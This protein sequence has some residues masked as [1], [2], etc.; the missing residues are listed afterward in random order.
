LKWFVE[1]LA[2]DDLIK[3]IDELPKVCS[4]KLFVKYNLGG[5]VTNHF[6]ASPFHAINFL[7]PDKFKEWEFNT[8]KHF[9]TDD[10]NKTRILHW[11]IEKL[12][13]EKIITSIEDIP[14]R[15]DINTFENY[16]LGSFVRHNFDG[17]SYKAFNFLF[18]DKWHPWEF[19]SCPIGYWKDKNNVK[20]ALEWFVDRLIERGTIDSVDQLRNLPVTKLFSEFNLLSISKEYN[21][22]YGLLFS[23]IL[24]NYFSLEDFG[25][26]FYAFDGTKLD[27]KEEVLIHEWLIS[28][29]KKVMYF[30]NNGKQEFKWHNEKMNENYVA[31]WMINDNIIIEYFGWYNPT[32]KHQR[33][34]S[35]NNKVNRKIDYFNGLDNFK[36]VPLF[37]KDI[38]KNLE[39]VR[40]KIKEVI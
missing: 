14:E 20:H 33:Y 16:N 24:P 35:Y 39:G 37:P 1:K 9:M 34:V 25:K 28:N 11:F 23:T 36:F 8:P 2:Q 32:S 30:N 13:E 15:V 31:D 5:L 19:K 18:P 6:N 40:N 10:S 12:L 26:N 29:C 4:Y 21:N 27:S 22:N 17:V 3:T 7:Y 38:R